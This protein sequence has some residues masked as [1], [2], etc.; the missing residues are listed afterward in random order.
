MHLLLFPAFLAAGCAT[1]ERQPL[2]RSEFV[3]EYTERSTSALN[4]PETEALGLEE[5]KAVALF[6]NPA[7]RSARLKAQIPVLS[8]TKAGLWDDPELSIDALRILQSVEKPWI[9]GSSIAFTLPISGRLHVEKARAN[10]E[11]RAALVAAWV[12]EQ[13]VL[14]EL[15]FEWADAIAGRR[16]LSASTE[17]QRQLDE[18]VA[19]TNRL[20]TSGELITAEAVAFR[21]AQSRARLDA[22]RLAATASES[23]ARILA[24][25][26]LLPGSPVKLGLSPAPY[27]I[28]AFPDREA[29]LARNPGVLLREAE[30]EV[31]EESLRLEVRRQYPDIQLGPAY[32]NEDGESRLGIGFSVPLPILNGNQR[33]IIEAKA[34]RDAARGSWEE[35]VQDAISERAAL[36]AKLTTVE[37]R[38]E[39][40][41]T[42]VAS[43]SDAQLA[44]ARRLADHGEVNALLLL[45]ALQTQ[46]EVTLDQIET[47]AER[48]RLR[49]A[50][51]A[52]APDTVPTPSTEVK[53]STP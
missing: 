50:L 28:V 51:R 3:Q 31:A 24:L 29:L 45:E 21:V 43:L 15:E 34:T 4:V 5:A 37:R 2:V 32:G 25:L 40:L 22:E 20:E 41:A 53:G 48:D 17:A 11:A 23:E 14:Q 12:A 8:A 46:H 16:A 30:Y 9:I 13:E 39:L 18:V 6:F 27:S 44:E 49:G 7:V 42:G 36:E 33:A 10:A 47:D 1:Y 26:G 19:I 52:L 35:A 38:R